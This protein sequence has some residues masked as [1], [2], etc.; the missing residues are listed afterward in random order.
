MQPLQKKIK[1]SLKTKRKIMQ[2]LGTKNDSTSRDKKKSHNVSGQKNHTNTQD[3]KIIQ[4]GLNSSNK[5][6]YG[7]ILSNMVQYAKKNTT[8]IMNLIGWPLN[9]DSPGSSC[10]RVTN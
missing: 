6:K 1:Q 8:I 5:I 2:P 3:K 4:I 7:L 9:P 10:Q